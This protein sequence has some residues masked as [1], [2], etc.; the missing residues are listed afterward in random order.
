M[1]PFKYIPKNPEL[2]AT[3]SEPDPICINGI[4]DAEILADEEQSIYEA[5]AYEPAD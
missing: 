1:K 5:I 2:L 3:I 4:E